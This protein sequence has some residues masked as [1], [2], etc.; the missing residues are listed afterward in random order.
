MHAKSCG[1]ASGV[2]CAALSGVVS[3]TNIHFLVLG[4][5]LAADFWALALGG[6]LASV[7][8]TAHPH[9]ID[10]LPSPYPR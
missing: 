8:S 6:P 9:L 10:N 1:S 3:V 4:Y 7:T 5:F 2:Y